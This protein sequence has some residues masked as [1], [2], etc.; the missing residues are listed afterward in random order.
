MENW[1]APQGGR[2][3]AGEPDDADSSGRRSTVDAVMRNTLENNETLAD[4]LTSDRAAHAF[5]ALIEDD[6]EALR[7]C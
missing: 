7:T 4:M 1:G 5:A 6:P 3:A 2:T